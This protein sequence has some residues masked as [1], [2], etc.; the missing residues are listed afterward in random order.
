MASTEMM[1]ATLLDMGFGNNRAV[2]GLQATGFKGA[3][4]AME[5]LLARSD[6]PSLDED[7]TEE[8]GQQMKESLEKPKPEEKKP[9]T[10]EEKAEKLARLEELRVK[11]RA[12]REAKE[13]EEAR[14]KE[15]S[16]IE[17]GKDMGAIR[18]AL[19]EQEIRK[20]AEQRRREKEDDKRARARVLEQIAA[21]KAERLAKKEG[22]KVE[23]AKPVPVAAA[24]P[25][26]KKDYSETRLQIRQPTGQPI[27]HTFGVKEQLSAVRLYIQMNRTDGE[28]GPV[29]LM[30]SFPKKVFSED[31]YENTLENLG[32]VPSAVLMVTK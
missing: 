2:R 26:V 31:D 32:L 5:W 3:E 17:S 15:K 8:E 19:A 30:T 9:L 24:P 22:T 12:E 20:L 27:V 18:E 25:P 14:A 21:D 7:F 13:A 23:E 28:A 1:M 16:R 10:E 11:K 6:D 29:K 4:A